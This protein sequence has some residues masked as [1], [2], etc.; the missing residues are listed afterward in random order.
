MAPF[1]SPTF[2]KK[3]SPQPKL[4][5]TLMASRGSPG[6]AV[7]RTFFASISSRPSP[8]CHVF[9]NLGMRSNIPR[10]DFL[11]KGLPRR[12]VVVCV[13]VEVGFIVLYFLVS[14]YTAAM[15]AC[16]FQKSRPFRPEFSSWQP[17]K[18]CYFYRK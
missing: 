3:L 2:I 15:M 1:S 16:A 11:K 9:S 7:E 6:R 14:H 4:S 12:L 18:Y 17:P 5:I 10:N 8:T 13:D